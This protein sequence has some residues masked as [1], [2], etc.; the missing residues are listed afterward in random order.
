MNGIVSRQRFLSCDLMRAEGL[1]Q[2]HEGGGRRHQ[3][4]GFQPFDV[5]LQ[6][7][8]VHFHKAKPI[9]RQPFRQMVERRR[10]RTDVER[11]GKRVHKPHRDFRPSL[12]RSSP[13]A[14]G[15]AYQ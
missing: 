2:G 14:D 6:I 8:V 9:L 15:D 11:G 1:D 4:I 10:I 5:P 7:S 13:D 12:C 3:K